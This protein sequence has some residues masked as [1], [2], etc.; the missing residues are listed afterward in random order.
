MLEAIGN[1]EGWY[2][3][4]RLV[5]AMVIGTLMGIER[6][7]KRRN[8]GIKTHVL[9]CIGSA[10]VMMTSQYVNQNFDTKVDLTRLG[11]QVISGVGFLGVG[12]I[13]VTGKNHVKGLTTAAGL[14][15]CACEGLAV[16]I[17]FMEGAILSF[18]AI[19][20]T[21]KVLSKL[22]N[23]SHQYAKSF[24]LY[25]EFDKNS[26]VRLFMHEMQNKGIKM[27]IIEMTK[28]KLEGSGPILIMGF[29]VN[30]RK[31]RLELLDTIRELEYV[32][33]IEEL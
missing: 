24:E 30:N 5:V 23:W 12:T 10:L 16:G 25:L 2:I 11:A 15:V 14:W 28:S 21:L 3:V 32:E 27:S 29:S 8:A 9:V 26:S 20:I 7:I 4:I 18:V 1:W 33:Y 6:G 13:I 22:D 17:G 31:D 19:M